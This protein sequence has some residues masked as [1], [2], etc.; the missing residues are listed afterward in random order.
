MAAINQMGGT[1]PPGKI[2]ASRCVLFTSSDSANSCACL[3][4]N[5]EAGNSTARSFLLRIGKTEYQI[6]GSEELTSD[7]LRNRAG[8][9]R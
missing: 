4:M 9:R 7:P 1:S 3:V 8:Q 6:S 2:A 5:S